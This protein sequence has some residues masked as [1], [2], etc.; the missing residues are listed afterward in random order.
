MTAKERK[1]RRQL[2][3]RKEEEREKTIC[4]LESSGP[5]EQLKKGI[6]VDQ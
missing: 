1:E 5:V 4:F 2:P 3:E 6:A